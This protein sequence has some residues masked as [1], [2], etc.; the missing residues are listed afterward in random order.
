MLP[1][2]DVPP[3]EFVCATVHANVV[4]VTLL[5]K[6]IALAVPEQIVCAMGE[7]VTTGI[8]LTLIVTLTVTISIIARISK[9]AMNPM[10]S[11]V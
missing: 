7:A 3:E 5:V 10:I 6:L 1:L 2:P 9:I 11:S 8:G 4:P